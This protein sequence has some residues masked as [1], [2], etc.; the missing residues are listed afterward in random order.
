MIAPGS[1]TKSEA[2]LW[3]RQ[4]SR[5]SLGV[6][7]LEK[8]GA[9]RWLASYKLASESV[10]LPSVQFSAGVQGIGTGNPGYALTFEKN[11]PRNSLP[12]NLYVGIGFR[13]NESHAHGLF[14]LR[15]NLNREFVL[16]IQHDGHAI[17]PFI[18][19]SKNQ[20]IAGIYL[21]RA[22]RPALLLGYRF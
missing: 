1:A 10:N 13:S 17:N 15:T 11:F 12:I 22:S 7:Y 3:Y 5:L 19:Y 21:V 18:T 2:F 20:N 8:Q 9:F 16:G 4:S 6:A 14:G